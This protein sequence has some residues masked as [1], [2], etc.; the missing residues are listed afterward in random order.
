MQSARRQRH[1]GLNRLWIGTD[2]AVTAP[3]AGNDAMT[4]TP[5]SPQAQV[6]RAL[7]GL[8]LSAHVDDLVA[9]AMGSALPA[10]WKA[11]TRV[12]EDNR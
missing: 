4:S 1:A 2:F 12:L 3:R 11:Q 10:Q 9:N 6:R 8:D 5:L 7:A